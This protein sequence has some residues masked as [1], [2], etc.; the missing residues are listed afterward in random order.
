MKVKTFS[1]WRLISLVTAAHILIAISVIVCRDLTFENQI[2]LIYFPNFT[3]E[4]M[5]PDLTAM[6]PS[7]DNLSLVDSSCDTISRKS[8][9]WRSGKNRK[10]TSDWPDVLTQPESEMPIFLEGSTQSGGLGHAFRSFISLAVIAAENR[11]TLRANLISGGHGDNASA[12]KE[13]IFGNYYFSR[14][15]QSCSGSEIH[16]VSIRN[17]ASV[18]TWLRHQGRKNGTCIVI[19]LVDR[20]DPDDSKIDPCS[21]RK[22]YRTAQ[23]SRI[24]RLLIPRPMDICHERI[25]GECNVRISVHLRRGDILRGP[26]KQQIHWINTRGSPNLVY[27]TLIKQILSRLRRQR[28][29]ADVTMHV[30][31]DGGN[32][33]HVIDLDGSFNDFTAV[34]NHNLG[35]KI[36]LGPKDTLDTLEDTCQSH[37]LIGS[38]SGF[39]H[40]QAVLCD[41]TVVIALPMFAFSYEYLPN[42]ILAA[43]KP[44]QAVN[45]RRFDNN[46]S[47]PLYSVEHRSL[48]RML[49][50]F[51]II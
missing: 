47:F 27:T 17:V 51:A 25:A 35:E 16:N 18:V 1:V 3:R 22:A 46:F 24:H 32:L 50:R 8:I 29:V 28:R 13:R 37:I 30:E 40:L 49:R 19:S 10:C 20:P 11:L 2:F 44:E 48:E 45:F 5:K 43:K 26:A 9:C 12:V 39:S 7:L 34:V 41:K 36:S 15:P 42:V 23:W 31:L 6:I 21:I 38:S 4:E 14:I 33:S